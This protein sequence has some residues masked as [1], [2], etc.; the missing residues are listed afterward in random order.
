MHPC[1]QVHDLQRYGVGDVARAA[2]PFRELF[3]GRK[4]EFNL[5]SRAN[6]LRKSFQRT[7]E[8]PISAQ[9]GSTELELEVARIT[10]YRP[11]MANLPDIQV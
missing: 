2:E 11:N 10:E 7:Q 4:Q 3:D 5:V 1:R 9:V 8:R 6:I